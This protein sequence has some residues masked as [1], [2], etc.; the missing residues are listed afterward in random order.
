M[1]N[2]YLNFLNT[3][4]NIESINFKS[5]EK[6]NAILEHVSYDSGKE[7]LTFIENE[8][9]YI[10]FQNILEFVNINDAYGVPNMEKFECNNG[11]ILYCSPT[12][13]R[14]VYH[15]LTILNYYKDLN[16]DS[17]VEVG[18]GYG[19]LFLA[20]SYFSK[21]LNIKINNYHLIDFPDVCTLIKK[22][23]KI[24]E[25]VI[26]NK[27]NYFLHSCYDYKNTLLEKDLF[28]ISNYCFTEISIEN[29]NDYIENLFDKIKNG[30]IIWQT[31]FGLDISYTG[32]IKK[33]I[34]QIIDEKPQTANLV[35][36]NYFVYF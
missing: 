11:K 31:I 29:R 33:S 36:K 5:N 10:S 20:I 19:G 27:I 7:Y 25:N 22:Y 24:N 8:H 14:Y 35:Q 12:S 2:D 26:D 13:L 17:I 9:S 34:K 6:Y 18:C 23:I 28:L 3:I 15:S 4:D 32:I 21:L 1:Y 16:I 30:F